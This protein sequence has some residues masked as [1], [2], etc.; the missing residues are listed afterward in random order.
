MSSLLQ[1]G[2]PPPVPGGVGD[3]LTGGGEEQEQPDPLAVLQDVI[4]QLP[5]LIAA[6]PDPTDTHEA[7]KALQTLSGIQKRLMTAQG[8][9]GAAPP[10]SR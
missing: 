4:E 9:G 7:I 6:L 2:T 10:P 1:G 5:G 3:L 8:S